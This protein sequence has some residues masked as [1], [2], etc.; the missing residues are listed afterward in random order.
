MSTYKTEQEEFWAGEFGNQYINRNNNNYLLAGKLSMFSK[1][2]ES[3]ERIKSVLEFG[4]NIGLNLQ[5]LGMLLPEAKLSAV[6]INE[7]AVAELKKLN[8]HQIFNE[9]ILNF[10]N[11][12]KYD[13][14]FTSG[15]LIHINP[16]ELQAV[17][18]KL[19]ESSGKYILIAEYYNPTPVEIEY[20]G[21]SGKLF[22]RDFAGE[23]LDKYPD[24]KLINYGFTYKRDN[25]FQYADLSWFLLSK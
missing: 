10:N 22:K 1:I 3:C 11:K 4:S 18:K 13:I 14:T 8:L 23:L 21:F 5:V 2:L 9:S 19:Y 16:E 7:K 12:D 17:Y 25:N 6:E 20:H 24:L 15:V